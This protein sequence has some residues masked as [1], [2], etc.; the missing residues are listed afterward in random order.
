M[1]ELKDPWLMGSFAKFI[2]KE[3]HEHLPEFYPKVGAVGTILYRGITLD[4]EEVYVVQWPKGSTSHNDIWR[5]SPERIRILPYAN[6]KDE[7]TF[8]FNMEENNMEENKVTAVEEESRICACCGAVIS[9][10]DDDYELSNGDVICQDCYDDEYFS[11]EC[12]GDIRHQD[13]V[14][15]V[16]RDSDYTEYICRDCA[17]YY[18]RYFQCEDCHEWFNENHFSRYT[19][20]QGD[21]IC[22]NCFSEG[23]EECHDCGEIYPRDDMSD[24]GDYFYCANCD[25]DRHKAIHEYGYKPE[26]VFKTT[27]DKFYDDRSIRELLFGVELEVDKG[28]DPEELAS[29]LSDMSEDIYCK[30]DGSLMEGVEIVTHP[31]TL[32]YHLNYFG[33]EDICSKALEYGFK[34]HD[35]RTCGLHVHVGRYQLGKSTREIKKT[36]SK[37]I[38]LVDRF[39]D[40]MVQFS[41]RNENQLRWARR[42][43]F[44]EVYIGYNEDEICD[45][46]YAHERNEG[47]YRAVNIQNYTTIE[48][49]IFNGTL[50]V[51]TIYAT[52]QLV[53]NI[54]GYAMTHD[55]EECFASQWLDVAKYAS[56][57]ELD[58][59]LA[60]RDLDKKIIHEAVDWKKP[61][62]VKEDERETKF[63]IGDTAVIMNDNGSGVYGL[64]EYRGEAVRIV[65]VLEPDHVGDYDYVVDFGRE[66]PGFT[67][68]D[69]QGEADTRSYY[70]VHEC[71]IRALAV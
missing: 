64:S 24:D 57:A 56:T 52:L 59:Y 12:C 67:H 48:F 38:F 46:I 66:I 32:A 54:C 45:S 23:Y 25:R 39:W 29:D 13:D 35:A 34:S 20:Y 21:T 40:E 9:E 53:S 49:R 69:S 6:L 65:R 41:R 70:Y 50:K 3:A 5:V 63:K 42:P 7:E 19:T 60:E 33:W 71:N 30:H 43:D 62:E 51:N 68:G 14:V 16:S 11:C 47:R 15:I 4:G 37:I 8:Y 61:K 36:I 58:Q 26:P 44:D 31:C 1:I 22:E 27:H 18:S 10:D 28:D 55:L 2:D 17:D